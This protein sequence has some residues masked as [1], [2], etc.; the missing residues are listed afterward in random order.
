MVRERVKDALVDMAGTAGATR[1]KLFEDPSDVVRRF[2][3]DILHRLKDPETP[4]FWCASLL[5]T[6]TGGFKRR[7]SRL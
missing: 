3:V 2:A 1:R 6:K 7:L 5:K 4:G